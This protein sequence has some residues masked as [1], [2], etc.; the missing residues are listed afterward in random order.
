MFTRFL[1]IY[2]FQN[3]RLVTSASERQE[4]LFFLCLSNFQVVSFL[5][6]KTFRPPTVTAQNNQS[7][8]QIQDGCKV[9]EETIRAN[10]ALLRSKA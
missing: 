7:V 5:P 6:E 4:N 9:R 8:A 1:K 2:L 10:L 3:L